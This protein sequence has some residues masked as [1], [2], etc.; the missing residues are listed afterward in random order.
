VTFEQAA[1]LTRSEK[2]TLVTCEA[3][4]L[5]K[6]FTVHSGQIYVRDVDYFVSSVKTGGNAL[7]S[8]GSIAEMTTETFFYDVL[9]KKIYVWLIGGD[10]PLTSDVSIV[11]KFFFSNAPLN[12][13]H[14]LLN[15]PDVEWLPYINSIGS[16]GQ[17]LDDSNIG[18]VLESSSSIDF[19]NNHGFFD[20]IFDKLIWENKNV[21]FFSWFTGIPLSEKKKIFSGVVESKDFAP[22][23]VT[24]KVKDFVFKLRNKVNL[25]EFSANDGEVLDTYIGSPKRRIYGRVSKCQAIGIDCVKSGYNLTGTITVT[26][27]DNELVGTGTAFLTE[28]SPGDDLVFTISGEEIKYTIDSVTDNDT[29]FFSKNVE[30]SITN[31]SSVCRPTIGYRFKNRR[32]HLAGHK[33]AT[34][35]AIIET[36]INSRQFV[37]NYNISEFA[38]DDVVTINGITTQIT[39]ISGQ[40]IILEQSIFPIPSAGDTIDKVPVLRAYFGNNRLVLNRDFTMTN[41]TE[42]IIEL[43]DLAEFNIAKERLSSFTLTFTNG[44]ANVTTASVVDLRTLIKPRDWIRKLTQTSEVWFEVLSVEAASLK[45]RSVFTQATGTEVARI[46][47]VDIILDDS[48]ITADCYGLVTDD[49]VWAYTASDIVKHLVQNDAG[50]TSVNTDSFDQAKSDCKYV[51]S[52]VIPDIGSKSPQIRD[53]I[54]MVNDSIFGSLYGNSSQELCYS[55]VNTRRPTTLASL[56]DDDILNWSSE[57]INSIVSDVKINYA[58]FTD[59]TSGEKAFQTELYDSTFVD[60]H[61]GILDT[62]EKTCYIYDSAAATAIAQ[63]IAFNKSLSTSKLTIQGK[64]LFFNYSVNDRIYLE[65]DRLY[66]RYGGSTRR[67]IGIVSSVKK[68]QYDSEIILNDLGGRFNRCPTIALNTTTAFSTATEDDKVKF[69]FILDADTLT[70]DITSED[71]LG[72]CLIG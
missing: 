2:I 39:R 24:F 45:L 28:L 29:A 35:Q 61:V 26:N 55:I 12:L 60:K 70:P 53:V 42:A 17:T 59:A 20:S 27:G 47:N 6:L 54:T 33:L 43:D 68:G 5:V 64:A 41:T 44:S 7:S 13:P 72:N 15:G 37:V 36:V 22:D 48:L 9:N 52:L 66:K 51:M 40:Q 38:A 62:E 19:M 23:K 65:L 31:L 69:G 50:F 21:E 67:K 11:Y 56:K 1:L 8:V 34:S 18:I 46:K 57:S 16:I 3:E 25:G 30:Q 49:A 63:R 58:P 32:W 10:N 71:E 4:Q 14:D